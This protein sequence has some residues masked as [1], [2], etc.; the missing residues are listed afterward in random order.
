MTTKPENSQRKASLQ[1]MSTLPVVVADNV[2]AVKR[3]NASI[4]RCRHFDAVFE[5]DTTPS[6]EDFQKRFTI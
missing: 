3:W 6:P 2:L 1:R 4:A 5:V